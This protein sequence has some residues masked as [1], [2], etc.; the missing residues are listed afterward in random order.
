[1]NPSQQLTRSKRCS[2]PPFIVITPCML[3]RFCTSSNGACVK[4]ICVSP[5]SFLPSP[6][7]QP[8]RNLFFNECDLEQLFPFAFSFRFLSL[9]FNYNNNTLLFN[10]PNNT[11]MTHL[12]DYSFLRK[13]SSSSSIIHPPPPTMKP[14][15]VLRVA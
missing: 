1:M 13:P 9:H 3:A 14:L 6:L 2:F 12:S 11:T 15:F 8:P 10:R 4:S 7:N 5:L